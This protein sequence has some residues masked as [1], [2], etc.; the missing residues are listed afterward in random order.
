MKKFIIFFLM[1][2]WIVIQTI[3]TLILGG[4]FFL[5]IVLGFFDAVLFL[6]LIEKID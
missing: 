3:A 1:C 5:D 2:C 6:Y 4:G